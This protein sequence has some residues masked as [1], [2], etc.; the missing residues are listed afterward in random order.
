MGHFPA[1]WLPR[2]AAERSSLGLWPD[3]PHQLTEL[4]KTDVSLFS[5]LFLYLTKIFQILA[6]SSHKFLAS[7]FWPK[8]G[9][10]KLC[11]VRLIFCLKLKVELGGKSKGSL[12]S[13]QVRGLLE[14]GTQDWPVAPAKW[15]LYLRDLELA[16]LLF[17][18]CSHQ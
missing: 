6:G 7:A 2:A 1:A 11:Y 8:A 9:G 10:E 5:S 15:A 17:S 12:P 13:S 14:T 4:A 18:L 16:A 3:L